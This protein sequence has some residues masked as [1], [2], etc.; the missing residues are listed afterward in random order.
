MASHYQQYVIVKREAYNPTDQYQI[1]L[2]GVIYGHVAAK[3]IYVR[4]F[5]GTRHM[6]SRT[7]LAI[8]SWAGITLTLWVIAWIIAESIP[9]FNSLLGL[10][11]ALFASW[12]TYGMS[13]IFW[14]YLNWGNYTLNW[15]KMSLTALNFAIFWIGAAI[16]GIGLYASGKSIHDSPSGGSWSCSR[17]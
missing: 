16:C 1:L 7:W 6:G 13:G 11:S 4:I 3:Y 15:K 17:S 9:N 8:G 12:F 10:I 14:L 2:A 5:R